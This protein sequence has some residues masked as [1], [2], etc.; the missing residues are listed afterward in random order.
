[1]MHPI[2]KWP[3][4]RHFKHQPLLKKENAIINDLMHLIDTQ[5]ES[6]FISVHC[7]GKMDPRPVASKTILDP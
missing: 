2:M 4:H 5:N 7:L 6:L 1:L 3:F